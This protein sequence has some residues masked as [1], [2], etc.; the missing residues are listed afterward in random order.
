MKSLSRLVYIE[1]D[2]V[3]LCIQKMIEE[4]RINAKID[5]LID[6]VSFIRDEDI[7]ID[8]NERIS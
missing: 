2:I 6:T 3:E 7:P 4:K 8:F 1:K 5:Q